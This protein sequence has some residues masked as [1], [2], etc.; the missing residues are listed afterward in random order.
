[1]LAFTTVPVVGVARVR[2]TAREGREVFHFPGGREITP[3]SQ[4]ALLFYLQRLRDEAIAR[5]RHA[6]AR[7]AQ[8][9]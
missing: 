2:I 6:P 3:S 4:S 8:S 9:P 7:S 1:M 5:H